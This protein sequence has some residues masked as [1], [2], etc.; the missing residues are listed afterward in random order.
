MRLWGATSTPSSKYHMLR[1][2][3][4]MAGREENRLWISLITEWRATEERSGPGE[5]PFWDKVWKYVLDSQ[6][7]G[8]ALDLAKGVG[9]VD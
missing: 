6:E 3:A 2:S 4:A 7:D 9:Q 1:E 8:L 5:S